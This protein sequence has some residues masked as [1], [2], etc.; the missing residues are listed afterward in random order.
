MSLPE[1]RHPRRETCLA[2]A[3]V[4]TNSGDDQPPGLRRQR[5]CHTLGG[6]A[7]CGMGMVCGH[8]FGHKSLAGL[9]VREAPEWGAF[10]ERA[11]VSDL[12]ER[13]R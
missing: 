6:E 12:A 13:I 11:R 7:C 5:E 9:W 8:G 1:A 3:W 2:G 4:F 10:V